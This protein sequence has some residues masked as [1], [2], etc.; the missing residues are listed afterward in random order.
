MPKK[1]SPRMPALGKG[2][3]DLIIDNANKVKEG[4]WE[5][6]KAYRVVI[7]AMC[8]GLRLKELRLSKVNDL[9]E[10]NMIMKVQ[11]PKGEGTYG[12]PRKA[13]IR[14]EVQRFLFKYLKGREAFVAKHCPRNQALIP[15]M[16]DEENG[17]FSTNGIE[18]LK[19]IVGRE[20]GLDFDLRKCRRTYGQMF[21]DG[22]L[23]IGSISV[24][25]GHKTTKTTEQ[26]YCRK[27]DEDA[28][29]EARALTLSGASYPDAKTRK[30]DFRKRLPGYA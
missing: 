29:E 18:K 22:E 8:A 4:D 26:Y 16:R 23:S 25:M 3:Y 17:F 20:T 2:A 27:S 12:E 9:N 21:I 13:F 11:H 1:T 28:I 10:Y 6:L 7:L 19:R 24:M 30:I 14:P 15:T 5:R